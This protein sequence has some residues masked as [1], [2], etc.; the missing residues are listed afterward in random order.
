MDMTAAKY[1]KIFCSCCGKWL[2]VKDDGATTKGVYVYCG[3]CRRNVEVTD[4]EY[5]LNNKKSAKV[6]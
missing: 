3:R 1:N 5:K 2:G 4:T 6:P